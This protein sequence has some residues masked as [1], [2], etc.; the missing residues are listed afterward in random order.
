ML[1]SGKGDL[2]EPPIERFVRAIIALVK[3]CSECSVQC[4]QRVAS[5]STDGVYLGFYGVR[6][7][8]PIQVFVKAIVLEQ[9]EPA[10]ECICEV[11][12][13]KRVQAVNQ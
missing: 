4:P 8:V 12:F 3:E 6:Y 13:S 1:L 10:V 11:E 5:H 9:P 7:M 2:P